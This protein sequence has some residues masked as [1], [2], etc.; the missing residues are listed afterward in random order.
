MTETVSLSLSV[1]QIRRWFVAD[2]TA[3][4]GESFSG[5]RETRRLSRTVPGPQVRAVL[6]LQHGRYGDERHD[7]EQQ[8]QQHQSLRYAG[9]RSPRVV[10][11]IR[12]RLPPVYIHIY[13]CVCVC[14]YTRVCINIRVAHARNRGTCVPNNKAFAWPQS[15]HC[16]PAP[17]SLDLPPSPFLLCYIIRSGVREWCSWHIV[18]L[19]GTG[20]RHGAPAQPGRNRTRPTP[21][22]LHRRHWPGHHLLQDVVA[23]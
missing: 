23:R 12:A 10:L 14:V 7:A 1:S 2:T 9:T 18:R 20:T 6:Q 16:P 3:G 8:G 22:R 17:S 19:C 15:I 5:H 21:A 4:S 13:T 11:Y